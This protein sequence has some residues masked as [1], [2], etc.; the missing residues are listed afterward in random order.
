[1]FKIVLK[2]SVLVIISFIFSCV[3]VDRTMLIV[4]GAVPLTADAQCL[5]TLPDGTQSYLQKGILE[6][7]VGDTEKE[8]QIAMHVTYPFTDVPLTANVH[9]FLIME[10]YKRRI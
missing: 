3:A 10:K 9:L 4:Q 1:M 7:G 8:Y 6:L 2:M 5:A